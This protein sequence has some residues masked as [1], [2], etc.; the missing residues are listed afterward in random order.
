M[1]MDDKMGGAILAAVFVIGV[2]L[3]IGFAK[4]PEF[5]SF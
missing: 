4:P 3:V 2:W 1:K 5:F